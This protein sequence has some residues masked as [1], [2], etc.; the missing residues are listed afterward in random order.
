MQNFQDL[1][2]ISEWGP[3]KLHFRQA[4]VML[5]Q[6]ARDSIQNCLPT[7]HIEDAIVIRTDT[8]Q[9][10]TTNQIY[11]LTTLFQKMYEGGTV[12]TLHLQVRKPKPKET[13]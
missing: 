12:T 5:M 10:L 1:P 4:H 6:V 2:H 9:Q 11:S 13:K 8:F 3:R 7:I